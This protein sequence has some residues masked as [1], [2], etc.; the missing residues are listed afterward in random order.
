MPID[1]AP[2]PHEISRALSRMHEIANKDPTRPHIL[3]WDSEIKE[4]H[5]MDAKFAF[6]LKW[7]DLD[8]IDLV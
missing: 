8:A 4:L 2:K 3:E 1:D 6:F 5:V 7:G